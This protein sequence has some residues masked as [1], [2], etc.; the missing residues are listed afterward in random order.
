MLVGSVQRSRRGVCAV[1]QRRRRRAPDDG[2][3]GYVAPSSGP[4]SCNASIVSRRGR[5]R[6]CWR[7]CGNAAFGADCSIEWC[8]SPDGDGGHDCWAGSEDEACECSAREAPETGETRGSP[9]GTKSL[10]V[11]VLRGRRRHERRRGM[12]DYEGDAA[13]WVVLLI[14]FFCCVVPIGGVAFCCMRPANAESAESEVQQM[15]MNQQMQ[16]RRPRGWSWG[17]HN[18][19]GLYGAQPGLQMGY[20]VGQLHGICRAGSGNRRATRSGNGDAAADGIVRTAYAGDDTSLSNQPAIRRIP[21]SGSANQRQEGG[22]SKRLGATTQAC[23]GRRLRARVEG[24]DFAAA[25][26]VPNTHKS[27]EGRSTSETGAGG[28]IGMRGAGARRGAVLSRVGPP[29]GGGARR[30]PCSASCGSRKP[31][32]SRAGSAWSSTPVAKARRSDVCACGK[33]SSGRSLAWPCAPWSVKFIGRSFAAAGMRERPHEAQ[34]GRALGV[35]ELAHH[36]PEARDVRRAAG[37]DVLVLGAARSRSTST[38][39][40]PQSS[41]RARPP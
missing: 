40:A 16:V 39:R 22:G 37:I 21:P 14:L 36:L 12:H 25:L 1:V 31:G 3:C 11:H 8:R 15:P 10:R 35:V 17:H 29:S 26:H 6:R 38:A 13:W 18:R 9:V 23:R 24:G 19:R 34:E 33:Y 7:G 2:Y 4:R 27:K 5:S 32:A 30:R 41:V 20:V 28:G